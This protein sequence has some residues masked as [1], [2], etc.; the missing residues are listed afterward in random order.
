MPDDID[1][2]VDAAIDD[3]ATDASDAALLAAPV[4]A[5][6][7]MAAPAPVVSHVASPAGTS[8]AA[9]LNAQV[10]DNAGMV[11]ADQAQ[12]DAVAAQAPAN[13]AVAE[14]K[15]QGLDDRAAQS[16]IDAQEIADK[17]AEFQKHVAEA[18]ARADA[19]EKEY[20]QHQFHNRWDEAS[21]PKRLLGALAITFGG[22]GGDKNQALEVLNTTLAR[23]MERQK[24]AL[25]SKEQIAKW[26][27]EGVKDMYAQFQDEMGIVKVRQATQLQAVADK[28]EAMLVRRGI[29]AAQ[30]A[31]DVEVM[32][33]RAAAAK[34]K[35]DGTKDLVETKLRMAQTNAA[36]ASAEQSRGMA[37][38]LG[39]GSAYDAFRAAVVAGDTKHVG[40][41]ATAA[42]IHPAQIE[43]EVKK[44]NAN[45]AGGDDDPLAIRD[46]SGTVVGRVS[47]PRM[48]KPV[49]DRIVQYDNALDALRQ[50]KASGDHI[51]MGPAYDKAVLAVAAVTQANASDKTTTHEAGTLKRY[52]LINQ[53][54][55]DS[56]I[57]DLETRQSAFGRQLRPVKGAAKG[58]SQPAGGGV[59]AGGPPSALPVGAIDAGKTKDGHQAYW[60][61][62][63]LYAVK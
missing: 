62:G 55:V 52:G 57:K 12:A 58:E 36:N 42:G 29:P 6:N 54:A 2:A 9:L 53:A 23:D 24:Q 38:A 21:T 26:R 1:T 32:K 40:A 60:L 30:A 51:A 10:A 25:A 8:N 7:P 48:V 4:S 59:P 43:D 5:A 18:T 61:N 35:Q 49:Q 50:L 14:A 34:A 39:S 27:R 28:A 31:N 13:A 19:A 11:A 17:E 63:K 45:Q 22:L 3:D 37:K 56:V 33:L 20:S 15:A 47:S 41:L 16:A 44:I 46:S